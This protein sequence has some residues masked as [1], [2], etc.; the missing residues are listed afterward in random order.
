MAMI[1]HH[2]DIACLENEVYEIVRGVRLNPSRGRR[3]VVYGGVGNGK[4]RTGKALSRWVN[5]AAI[6]LPLVSGDGAGGRLCCAF[7]IHWPS[8][9]DDFKKGYWDLDEALEADLLVIDDI[10]AEHDPSG[11]GREKLYQLLERREGKWDYITTNIVPD[12]W[13]NKFEFRIAD[14]LFRN[15]T[16]V[17]FTRVPSYSTSV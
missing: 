14:R 12:E 8:V 9:V 15:A 7:V 4:T 2:P 5:R 3:V 11:I 10:G 1:P 17:D 13:K 6:N 16:H